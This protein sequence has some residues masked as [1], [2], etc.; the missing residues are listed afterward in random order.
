MTES[1][2]LRLA[3][4]RMLRWYDSA[5]GAD[6]PHAD[7][8]VVVWHHGSPATGAPPPPLVEEAAA[9]GIRLLSYARPSYAGSTPR[10]G[11]DVASAAGDVEAVADAAGVALFASVGYSGGGPHALATAALLPSRVTGVVTLAGVAPYTDVFD[12][13]AG[14]H[15][16]GALRAALAGRD[17]RARFAEADE[18]DP[19]AF[20]PA[21]LEA[22]DGRWS[23]IGADAGRAEAAGPDGLVDDDVA[24]ANDW[25]FSLD[26]VGAPVLVVQG[27]H[28]RIVPRKHAA[29]LM[30]RLR[31]GTMWARLDDGHVSIL[32]TIP[33]ALDWLRD[34]AFP[35]AEPARHDRTDDHRTEH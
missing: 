27:E 2:D 4:G 31:D 35:P 20:L 8:P 6:P 34:H 26:E 14:M 16:P 13:F 17:A 23:W 10:P 5:P 25:G 18:F 29:W 24:Y 19:E 22:L 30:S 28:D 33:D 3:D 12:W 21:D 32:D 15:A 11:R 7:A 9:R 1:R